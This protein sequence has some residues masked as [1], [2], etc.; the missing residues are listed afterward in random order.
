MSKLIDLT[1]K[2]YGRLTVISYSRSDKRYIPFW[3]CICICGVHSVVSGRSL[4]TGHTKSCGCISDDLRKSRAKHHESYKNKTKEYEAWWEMKRRCLNPKRKAYKNYGG[5]GIKIH[6][7]WISSYETFLNDV[8]R[9]PTKQH[10]LD[11]I[12]NNGHYEPGNTK[13]STR[14][15]QSNNRRGVIFIEIDGVNKPLTTWCDEFGIPYKKARNRFYNGHSPN[16]IFK[17][18]RL[19]P[20]RCS[21]SS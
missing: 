15:E 13:W 9:A 14:K 2:I 1:G 5:R 4:K 3:N 18:G 12:D 6:E 7:S 20:V 16:K 19:S 10:S 17:K 8:G 21:A 11:R